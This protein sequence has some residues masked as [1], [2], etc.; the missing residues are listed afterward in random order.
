[1]TA[2]IFALVGF[3]AG[4]FYARQ[5]AAPGSP[6]ISP[7]TSAAGL[8]GGF[9][10]LVFPGGSETRNRVLAVA[11]ELVHL[12]ANPPAQAPGPAGPPMTVQVPFTLVPG[13]LPGSSSPSR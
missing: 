1:M 2:I 9:G 10:P 7:Q 8:A 6:Q 12:A 3:G 11:S 13:A 4:V 5:G